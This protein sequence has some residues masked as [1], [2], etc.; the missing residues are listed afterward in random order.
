[1]RIQCVKLYSVLTIPPAALFM[2]Y[3]F[4]QN[5]PHPLL[6]HS[7]RVRVC[8]HYQVVSKYKNCSRPSPTLFSFQVQVGFLVPIWAERQWHHYF[9]FTGFVIKSHLMVSLLQIVSLCSSSLNCSDI[10][11][12]FQLVR[13]L[14]Y[15]INV[16]LKAIFGPT[17]IFFM[18]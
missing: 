18:H 1:M 11:G 6:W 16:C 7:L 3:L 4:F 14:K 5:S 8:K 17:A 12:G 2:F 13:V 9:C 10:H 15:F